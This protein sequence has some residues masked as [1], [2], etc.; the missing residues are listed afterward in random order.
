[1]FFLKRPSDERIQQILERESLRP[2]TYSEIGAS[3]L[4]A[5]GGY[6]LNHRRDPIGI[7]ESDYRRAVQALRRWA[8]YDLPWTTLCWPDRPVEP[9][10]VVG[11]L[12]WHFGFWSLNPCRIVYVLEE[13]DEQRHRFGF[14]IG[15]L[16]EH[17]EQG[18]ERFTVEWRR[19]DDSVWFEIYTFARGRHPLVRMTSPLLL[20]VQFR[21]GREAVAAMRRAV[22][23]PAR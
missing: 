3:R 14:A 8:M 13:Q 21:F 10:V 22:R 6:P 2:F 23:E 18:E 11:V 5:P 4:R 16:P 12:V 15:T 20:R 9:G 17:A 19:H 1:M 7:G